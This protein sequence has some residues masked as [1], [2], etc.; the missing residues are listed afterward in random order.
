MWLELNMLY[1]LCCS[2]KGKIYNTIVLYSSQQNIN[3]CVLYY[4]CQALNLFVLKKWLPYSNLFLYHMDADCYIVHISCAR[5][6]TNGMSLTAFDH[7]S[8]QNYSN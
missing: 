3:G 5:K 2:L 4:K 8:V 7:G 6:A 1:K